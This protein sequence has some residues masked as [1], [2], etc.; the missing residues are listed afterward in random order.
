MDIHREGKFLV[1][2]DLKGRLMVG[3]ESRHLAA[4]IAEA[5]RRRAYGVFGTP[6][7]NF[8]EE[9]LDFLAK[10]P[11]VKSVWFWD[12]ALN[13]LDG[14]YALKSLQNVGVHGQRP[15]IDFGRLRNLTDVNWDFNPQDV[16]IAKLRKLRSLY[17]WRYNPPHRSFAGLQFPSGLEELEFV[18]GNPD[19]LAG[20]PEFPRLK[21]LIIRRFRNLT[22]IAEMPRIAPNVEHLVI[23][24][25]GRVAD[26]PAV[27]RR[28]P[29]LRHAWVRDKLLVT[30]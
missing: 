10:L 23:T 26:G 1:D 20:L 9:N 30:R 7:F 5:K 21:R 29:K 11:N 12:V 28:L 18:W 24:A 25:C 17:V 6:G 4:C 8:K 3:M 15:P 2:I 13:N 27:V 22:S 19:T 14:L 16:G